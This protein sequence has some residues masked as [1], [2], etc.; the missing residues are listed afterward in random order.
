[1][2]SSPTVLQKIHFDQTN[3]T[4]NVTILNVEDRTVTLHWSAEDNFNDTLSATLN[5]VDNSDDRFM[6]KIRTNVKLNSTIVVV[7]DLDPGL[8]YVMYVNIIVNGSIAASKHVLVKTTGIPIPKIT[9]ATVTT[10]IITRKAHFMWHKPED[11]QGQGQCKL[12][13]FSYQF[14]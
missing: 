1:M 3:Y 12:V 6:R 14:Y 8:H 10:N 2:I 9:N 4:L 13:K 7:D 11:N 5:I